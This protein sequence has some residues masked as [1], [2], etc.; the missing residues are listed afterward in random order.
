MTKQTTIPKVNVDTYGR[1]GP[2][3]AKFGK[4]ARTLSEVN[5]ATDM[6]RN[7]RP[8]DYRNDRS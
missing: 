4:G 1:N 2:D 8:C 5:Q 3:A 7:Q 6:R